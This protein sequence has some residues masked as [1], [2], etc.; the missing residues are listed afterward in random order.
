MTSVL[1]SVLAGPPSDRWLTAH[2]DPL[3]GIYTFSACMA[4]SGTPF[5]TCNCI[6]ADESVKIVT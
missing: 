1:E 5:T 6:K 3:A 2:H 4:L